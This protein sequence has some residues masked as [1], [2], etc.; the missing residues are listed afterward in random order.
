[1]WGLVI[2][3]TRQSLDLFWIFFFPQV[4][5]FAHRPWRAVPWLYKQYV[6]KSE[7]LLLATT[8]FTKLASIC[9]LHLAPSRLFK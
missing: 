2:K 5:E 7:I 4:S 8:H 3:G 6:R 1:M 9:L